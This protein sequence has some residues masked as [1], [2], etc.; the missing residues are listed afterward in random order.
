M[1]NRVSCSTSAEPRRTRASRKG[2]FILRSAECAQALPAATRKAK[3]KAESSK[4]RPAPSATCLFLAHA[5][6]YN[7]RSGA[8]PDD[9]RGTHEAAP[10]MTCDCRL[11]AFIREDALACASVHQDLAR[12]PLSMPLSR[13]RRPRRG[14]A[15]RRRGPARGCVCALMCALWRAHMMVCIAA[16]KS[17]ENCPG[18]LTVTRHGTVSYIDTSIQ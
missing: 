9:S 1:C 12:V 7:Y 4:Q 6:L 11:R 13:S 16:I 10:Y 14:G 3:G 18:K 15:R 5:C 8:R 17:I 2:R